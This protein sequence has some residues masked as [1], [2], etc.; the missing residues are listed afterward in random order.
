MMTSSP[1]GLPPPPAP[2]RPRRFRLG[3]AV[4]GL[5]PLLL[6]VAILLLRSMS[7]QNPLALAMVGVT[8]FF[9]LPLAVGLI[10]SWLSRSNLLR[11]LALI[12]AGSF[13]YTT[14]PVD[15]VVGCR[16]VDLTQP[17]IGD[18]ITIYTAN[19]LWDNP[20]TDEFA[21]AVVAADADI[22]V[23]QEVR[24]AFRQAL[25][26]DPRLDHLAH[27]SSDEVRDDLTTVV[28]SRWAFTELE[29]V[30]FEVT[31]VVRAT[32][33]GPSGPFTVYGLHTFAPLFS[34]NVGSWERQ[35]DQ[36]GTIDQSTPHVLAGDFNA[37][38]DHRQFRELMATGWTNVHDRKGCGLD[39]TWPVNQGI[40]V[41]LMRLDHVLVT[42]HFEV[43][44]VE[45][46]HTE[47]SDHDPVIAT[48]T[49][50]SQP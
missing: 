31:D 32:V 26:N 50:N 45:I 29:L 37:T 43:L 7:L 24:W 8:P 33:D 21:A 47:G 25:E 3:W 19:T 1:I 30:P 22:V 4:L 39:N 34:Q 41:P 23:M 18:P 42:D 5:P 48:I 44:D 13:V 16:G 15:A 9:A 28:W 46:G 11:A 17:G 38:S 6:V 49:M 2:R 12:V 14:S 20:H 36:L 40:P 10:G 35:L 27:R